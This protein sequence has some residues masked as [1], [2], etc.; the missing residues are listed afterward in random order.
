VIAESNY[1]RRLAYNFL[2]ELRELFLVEED[3]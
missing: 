1:P 3:P 2:L